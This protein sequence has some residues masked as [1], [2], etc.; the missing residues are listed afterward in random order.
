MAIL[1]AFDLSSLAQALEEIVIPQIGRLAVTAF[2]AFDLSSLSRALDED[3]AAHAARLS[4]AVTDAFDLSPL[5]LALEDIIATEVT[6]PP[7]KAV[8]EVFELSPSSL[9]MEDV[10]ATGVTLPAAKAVTNVFDLSPLSLAVEDVIAGE[11][12]RSPAKTST[13]V[14]DLSSLSRALDECVPAFAQLRGM[15]LLLAQCK[16]IYDNDTSVKVQHELPN[17]NYHLNMTRTTPTTTEFVNT[18]HD[19]I[20][21]AMTCSTISA[22]KAEKS[23]V[24]DVPTEI[25][26]AKPALTSKAAKLA[27]PV[28]PPRIDMTNLASSSKVV[29][30]DLKW[31]TGIDRC[32][33]TFSKSSKRTQPPSAIDQ[34][35]VSHTPG[36]NPKNK[37]IPS[38]MPSIDKSFRVITNPP[39]VSA[40]LISRAPATLIVS[41]KRKYDVMIGT[42]GTLVPNKKRKYVHVIVI[43]LPSTKRKLSD[44]FESFETGRPATKHKINLVPESTVVPAIIPTLT[45]VNQRS[46][47][48][49][50][51]SPAQSKALPPVTQGGESEQISEPALTKALLPLHQ[52]NE[53]KQ[54]K[55]IPLISHPKSL[56]TKKRSHDD[57]FEPSEV[58]IPKDPRKRRREADA[59]PSNAVTPTTQ[60]KNSDE[61]PVTL[62]PQ[63]IMINSCSNEQPTTRRGKREGEPS[64]AYCNGGDMISHQEPE[65]HTERDSSTTHQLDVDRQTLITSV[66]VMERTR[67]TPDD[68]AEGQAENNGNVDEF[69]AECRA[70]T[71]EETQRE[72]LANVEVED[73]AEVDDNQTQEEVVEEGSTNEEEVDTG[74]YEDEYEVEARRE[75]YFELCREIFGDGEDSNE[76]Y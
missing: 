51:S 57:A 7:A 49:L 52:C 62:L 25:V 27:A 58:F 10:I 9:A 41:K 61:P 72:D 40:A 15:C 47:S 6:L 11:V 44:A 34:S 20:T 60:S 24:V 37:A 2:K 19:N 31:R 65:A 22:R 21:A 18:G 46:E 38:K 12:T 59:R 33:S 74:E 48:E 39:N 13:D 23:R 76:D 32:S 75:L 45:P 63:D 35:N 5:S 28:K 70:V 43:T 29:V 56:P 30:E 1:S 55:Q 36:C 3:I 68:V 69:I 17:M 73:S 8:T 71:V 50:I 16:V 4:V 67:H 26:D 54:A 53:S 66:P 64:Q 42:L 14:F